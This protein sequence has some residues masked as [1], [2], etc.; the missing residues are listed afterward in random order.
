AN[1]CVATASWE[2]LSE[3]LPWS[4]SCRGGARY[5]RGLCWLRSLPTLGAIPPTKWQSAWARPGSLLATHSALTLPQSLGVQYDH[6]LSG[7]PSPLA[8]EVRRRLLEPTPPRLFFRQSP[9]V[10]LL[11]GGI[12]LLAPGGLLVGSIV[13]GLCNGDLFGEGIGPALGFLACP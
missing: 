12:F 2:T 10:A 9:W 6:P 1:G 5:G 7:N 3:T 8:V 4:G 13:T 11:F